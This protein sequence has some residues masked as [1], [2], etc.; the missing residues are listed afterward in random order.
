MEKEAFRDQKRQFCTFRISERHFGVDILNVKEIN[1][2]VGF[3][4]IFHAPK[5]VKGYVNIRGQI[6]LILDMR[7]ILGYGSKAVDESSHVVLFK[8]KD[9]APFGILVDSIGDVIT[10]DDEQ[11]ENRR[12]E[13][14]GPPEEGVERR[15]RD[16]AEGVCKLE[17]GLL[18]VLSSHKLLDI[19]GEL[20]EHGE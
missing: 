8:T 15:T 18:V 16:L 20:R 6:Y 4:P 17:D 10:A 3:T 11:I 13:D 19:I 5:E 7:L 12:L 1:P 9:I 14:Q 2:E